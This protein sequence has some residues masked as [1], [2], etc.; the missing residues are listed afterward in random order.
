MVCTKGHENAMEHTMVHTLDA[1]TNH[2]PLHGNKII[3]GLRHD[4]QWPFMFEPSVCLTVCPTKG[5]HPNGL[6]Y[7]TTRHGTTHGML[8]GWTLE[9]RHG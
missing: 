8:D 3:H 2:G 5:H 7:S 1:C 9:L 4:P 6:H